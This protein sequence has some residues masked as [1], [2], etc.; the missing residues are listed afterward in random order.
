MHFR[1]QA[2]HFYNYLTDNG[3]IGGGDLVENSVDASEFLLILDSD[4]V[5]GL[6]IVLK[7][8]TEIPA[9]Y[10]KIKFTIIQGSLTLY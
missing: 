8:S 7:R 4:T 1:N 6:V 2:H 10:S 9:K 3:V 5:I